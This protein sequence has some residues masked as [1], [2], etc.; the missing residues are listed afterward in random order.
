VA[1][2]PPSWGIG[3]WVVVYL[4][5]GV[6]IIGWW[7]LSIDFVLSLSPSLSLSPG[8]WVEVSVSLRYEWLRGGLSFF[9]GRHTNKKEIREREHQMR[10]EREDERNRNGTP[11]TSHTTDNKLHS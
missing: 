6:Q 1:S 4:S 9:L 5:V 10:R 8:G 7:F 11:Q 2:L 3:G